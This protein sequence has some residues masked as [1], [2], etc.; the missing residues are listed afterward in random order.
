VAGFEV[1][2][3]GFEYRDGCVF[4]TVVSVAAGPTAGPYGAGFE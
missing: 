1:D 4:R 2:S 3:T